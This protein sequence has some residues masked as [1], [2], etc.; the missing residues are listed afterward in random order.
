[1]I[2]RR[3]MIAAA[4]ALAVTPWTHVTPRRFGAIAK[5]NALEA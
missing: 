4:V 1:M 3:E 2:D 5:R